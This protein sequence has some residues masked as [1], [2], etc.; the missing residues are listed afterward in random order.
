MRLFSSLKQMS[1]EELVLQKQA[2][3]PRERGAI[4]GEAHRCRRRQRFASCG[5]VVGSFLVELKRIREVVFS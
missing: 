4:P 3:N 1:R 2:R 5:M